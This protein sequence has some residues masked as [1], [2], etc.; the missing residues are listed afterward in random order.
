MD[1]KKRKLLIFCLPVL[2][3]MIFSSCLIG[4]GVNK[5]EV[6]ADGDGKYTISAT[7]TYQTPDNK[8][9]LSKHAEK[10]NKMS[11]NSSTFGKL[12]I[13]GVNPESN[14]DNILAYSLKGDSPVSLTYTALFGNNSINGTSWNISKDS[15]T[16]VN[17]ISLKKASVCKGLFVLEKK[18]VGESNYTVTKTLNN[19][20]ENKVAVNIDS[21]SGDEINTGCYYRVTV[22][23]E[24][25]RNYQVEKRF[26]WWKWTETKTE[27][28]NC[29]ES[30]NFFVGRNSCKIQFLDLA[31]KDYSGYGDNDQQ[32]IIKNGDTLINDSVTVKGFK[33]NYLGN[34][35]YNVTYS[36][37]NKYV[38]EVKDGQELKEN[39]KYV[40][41]VKSLFGKE[42]STVIYVFN[43]GMDKGYAS[44]FGDSLL[45]G[46]Q[47]ADLTQKLETYQV[48][49]VLKLK[50]TLGNIPALRGEIVNNSTK[51]VIAVN[52]SIDEQTFALNT[53]GV[54]SVR[55][56]NGDTNLP[57]T[58]FTYNFA[59]IVSEKSAKP[60]INISNILTS[61]SVRDYASK[62]IEVKYQMDSGKIAHICFN[63]DDYATAYQFAFAVEK[64]Y[65]TKLD[66]AYLFNG[67]T[68]TNTL[69]LVEDMNDNIDKKISYNFF[70]NIN[71]NIFIDTS[72]L[73]AYINIED[74]NY[75]KDVYLTTAVEQG[76]MSL[77]QNILDSNFR[78]VQAGTYES[79]T[80]TAKN[81]SNNKVTKLEYNT[82]LG[83]MLKESGEYLITE[84]NQNN[85][86]IQYKIIYCKT[87]TASIT[88][89]V[90]GNEVVLSNNNYQIVNG[91]SVT[92]KSI[93]N[94]L[95]ADG[96]VVIAN[97]NTNK[98]VMLD[99]EDAQD[100][101][102]ENDNY[103]L[104]FMDRTGNTYNV[105][106]NCNSQ[107]ITSLSQAVEM[108]KNENQELYKY[109][110]K[111]KVS[112][113]T[114]TYELA[115]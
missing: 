54:Y 90:D 96:I 88:L 25:Y 97:L 48:G 58:Y 112:S 6:L 4:L 86:S 81:L 109:V 82:K 89:D 74:L 2:I 14:Y 3:L 32:N 30:Y 94:Q 50:A 21:L 76:R 16:K 10:W 17:G 18:Q 51:A 87:Y 55:L 106:I 77:R 26:L 72:D 84:T 46:K 107:K 33:V 98:V 13:G 93:V 111:Q 99:N 65:I 49:V 37:N 78:F 61:A 44:Y 12:E 27:Y 100:V 80:I 38:G 115:N 11:F 103:L 101:K 42:I 41:T 20:F 22:A 43:G 75:D 83:S 66:D 53:A 47:L 110:I 45:K 52:P 15:A 68:Y 73:S 8:N 39:G 23:Y 24:I 95:D 85:E 29:L 28:K 35:S 40:M 79:D 9:Y 56:V 108:I 114:N 59:F 31:E 7:C 36:R 105:I 64:K 60:S 63:K 70:T 102:L 104:T 34:K 1:I 91:T 57:G 67:K 69:E 71:K 113:L 92:I 62:F 5:R 19:I